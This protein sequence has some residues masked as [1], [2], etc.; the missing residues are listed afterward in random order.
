[1]VPPLVPVAEE[2][3]SNF[4]LSSVTIMPGNRRK[5][6][7]ARPQRLSG[8]VAIKPVAQAFQ[9]VP[10]QAKACGYNKHLFTDDTENAVSGNL[11]NQAITPAFEK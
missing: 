3:F 8:R 5:G 7:A 2:I 1:M 4:L 9:P 10:A 11:K 6:K